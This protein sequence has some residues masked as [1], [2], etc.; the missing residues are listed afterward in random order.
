MQV[1]LLEKM[2]NLGDLGV[3]V[4]VK[5]G[6]GRN[7]LIPKGK[8]VLATPINLKAFEAKRAEL[9]AAAAKRLKIAEDRMEKL[10]ALGDII[11]KARCGDEG[12]L[13]GSIGTAD[14][15]QAIRL[16]GFDLNRNEVR[17]S[18]STIRQLGEYTLNIHMQEDVH[19]T[20]NLIVMADS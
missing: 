12:R 17:L 3:T 8:A 18:Q 2:R 15:T 13:F 20:I 19:T 11:I 9:E 5:K 4:S 14:I 1:I 16:K 7:F 6:Y 10:L